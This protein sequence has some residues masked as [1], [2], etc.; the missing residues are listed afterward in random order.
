MLS[1]AKRPQSVNYR[2]IGGA[3][4]T[5]KTFKSRFDEQMPTSKASMVTQPVSRQQAVPSV[6]DTLDMKQPVANRTAFSF[7][8]NSKDIGPT[9]PPVGGK[10]KIDT[11][12]RPLGSTHSRLKT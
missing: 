3:T 5:N 8:G 9:A 10:A 1:N 11:G 7:T 4:R 2:A 12:N 6:Q